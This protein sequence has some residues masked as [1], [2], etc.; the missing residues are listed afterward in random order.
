MNHARAGL[1]LLQLPADG[2]LLAAGGKTS[3]GGILSS[4]ERYIP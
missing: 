4:A 3:S 1:A 2:V